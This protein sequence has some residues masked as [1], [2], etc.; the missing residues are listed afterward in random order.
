MKTLSIFS[1]LIISAFLTNASP[2]TVGNLLK[3]R[4]NETVAIPMRVSKPMK[5]RSCIWINGIRGWLKWASIQNVTTGE[6]GIID[7]EGSTTLDISVGDVITGVTVQ[8]PT[9]N[10]TWVI[11]QTHYDFGEV[12]LYLVRIGS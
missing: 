11:T 2:V 3:E 12:N 7:A 1:L 4:K 5:V 9:M 6:W 10:K 8:V